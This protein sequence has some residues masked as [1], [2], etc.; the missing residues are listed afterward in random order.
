MLVTPC[1]GIKS[2]DFLGVNKVLRAEYIFHRFSV[3]FFYQTMNFISYTHLDRWLDG[4][5][6]EKFLDL[7]AVK[8]LSLVFELQF[9]HL[10]ALII[11]IEGIFIDL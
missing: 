1:I 6:G 7:D 2:L 8:L 9:S 5:L 4:L 11:L 10:L 3:L